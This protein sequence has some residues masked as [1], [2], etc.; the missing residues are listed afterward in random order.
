VSERNIFFKKTFSILFKLIIFFLPTQLGLH[1]WPNFAFIRGVRFDYFAPTVYF[2]DVLL[3][4]LIVNFILISKKNTLINIGKTV[5][6]VACI[7]TVNS[8]FSLSLANSLIKS[9]KIFR[10]CKI[11]KTYGI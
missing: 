6:L 2:T 1:F 11:N 10:N 3:F 4:L 5:V 8:I 9:L 7:L